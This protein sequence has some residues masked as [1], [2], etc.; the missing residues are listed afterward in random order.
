[1]DESLL[2]DYYYIAC[3]CEEYDDT[4]G[5]NLDTESG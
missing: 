3:C 4:S 2:D 1:L 5:P